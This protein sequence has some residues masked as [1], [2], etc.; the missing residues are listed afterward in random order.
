MTNANLS[1]LIKATASPRAT[2]RSS[3]MRACLHSAVATMQ[4]GIKAFVADRHPSEVR[5]SARRA[6][7]Q[8]AQGPDWPI[9]QGT[10]GYIAT[11]T[12]GTQWAKIMTAA[13][14]VIAGVLAFDFLV[15]WISAGRL[16]ERLPF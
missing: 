9:D 7:Q 12:P 14:V 3:H 6:A 10:P 5:G 4:S 1:R 16:I 8:T 15:L 13:L 2:P 11:V